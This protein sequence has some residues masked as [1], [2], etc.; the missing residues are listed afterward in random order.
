MVS[1]RA[2]KA[3]VRTGPGKIYPALWVLMRTHIPLKVIETFDVWRKIQDPLGTEGWVHKSLLSSEKTVFIT[4]KTLLY[5]RPSFKGRPKVYLGQ[6]VSAK[7][8]SIT[9]SWFYVS[10]KGYKGYV[11][12]RDCWEG[13][14]PVL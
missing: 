7:L 3:N 9:P 14:L 2:S 4:R 11:A 10:I 5:T 12:R 6:G 13:S 1:L 8:I